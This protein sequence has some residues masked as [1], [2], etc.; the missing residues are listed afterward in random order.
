[1]KKVKVADYIVA[2]DILNSQISISFDPVFGFQ[3]LDENGDY[4]YMSHNDRTS[5]ARFKTQSAANN[6]ATK[7]LNKKKQLG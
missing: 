3:L 1:M 7:L 4:I 2:Y 5:T 6:F